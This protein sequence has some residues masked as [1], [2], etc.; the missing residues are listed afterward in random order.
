MPIQS[1]NDTAN[2]VDDY[3]KCLSYI[4]YMQ[5][6]ADSVKNLGTQLSLDPLFLTALTDQEQTSLT[7][8]VSVATTASVS[9]PGKPVV[10]PPIGP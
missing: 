9:L 10:T 8:A 1:F 2:F 3:K 7:T 6:W 5:Q 4:D